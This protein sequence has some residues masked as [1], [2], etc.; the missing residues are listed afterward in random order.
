MTHLW[1]IGLGEPDGVLERKG[2][3]ADLEGLDREDLGHPKRVIGTI[4]GERLE[5]VL[6]L[7][8]RVHRD[9]CLLAPRFDLSG[10]RDDIDRGEG[11]NFDLPAV[12]LELGLGQSDGIT[13]DLLILNGE[14]EIPVGLLNARDDLDGALPEL[15]VREVE[16]LAGDEGL[17]SGAV[18]AQIPHERLR[19][20]HSSNGNVL[21]GEEVDVVGNTAILEKPLDAAAV[22]L[23][24]LRDRSIVGRR[25]VEGEVVGRTAEGEGVGAL[26][27]IVEERRRGGQVIEATGGDDVKPGQL[28]VL[29]FEFDIDILLEGREDGVTEGPANDLPRGQSDRSLWNRLGELGGRNP[30]RR[31]SWRRDGVLCANDL[32]EWKNHRQIHPD[33]EEEGHD[34]STREAPLRRRPSLAPTEEPCLVWC[35]NSIHTLFSLVSRSLSA[36][37]RLLLSLSF[38]RRSDLPNHLIQLPLPSPHHESEPQ[39]TLSGV[40]DP[41]E[42]TRHNELNKQRTS[43]SRRGLQKTWPKPDLGQI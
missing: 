37:R 22:L 12:V 34:A 26:G 9:E 30:F 5:G 13:L 43:N 4:D 25:V 7:A 11:S 2:D 35:P 27:R 6:G 29:A 40:G 39:G 24:V 31:G 33:P 41:N 20:G 18:H 8:D 38:V 3:R 28:D 17:A 19:E 36:D 32:P 1:A 14:G 15:G 16:P 21:G 10:S 42:E 23:Q